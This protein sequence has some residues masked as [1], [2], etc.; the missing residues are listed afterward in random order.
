[1]G[2]AFQLLNAGQA[3]AAMEKINAL[4]LAN[5]KYVDG[6]LLRGNIYAKKNLWPQ[7]G[8]EYES[9]LAIDPTNV[10]AKFNLGETKFKVKDYDG[11]RAVFVT[12]QS[13]PNNGDLAAYKVFLCDLYGGHDDA[14][15]KE[16][17]A[18]NQAAT[19]AS[20]Y[21]SNVA[22]DLYHKKPEDA[23]GW[24]NSATNIYAPNKVAVYSVS[25]HDL[26]YLPL[27]PPPPPAQ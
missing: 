22:W 10:T 4:L 14:A 21:F 26:G 15:A 3:D 2:Q 8:K 13:D 18:F 24:L 6:Y 16:L 5:P 11:A 25:L 23:R 17:D 12:V 27:P 9:A 20:Y 19:H 1:M 7:A